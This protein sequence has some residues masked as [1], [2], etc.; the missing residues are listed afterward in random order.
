M[1]NAERISPFRR[2]NSHFFCCSG[3]PYRAKT[4]V[5]QKEKKNKNKRGLNED[6]TIGENNP[7]S[8]YQAQ[9]N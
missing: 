7:Y 4:S 8:Q 2:G 3:E 1:A 9:N 5:S 6:I